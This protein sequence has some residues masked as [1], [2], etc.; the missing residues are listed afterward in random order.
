MCLLLK[1]FLWHFRMNKLDFTSLFQ[2]SAGSEC[3]VLDLVQIRQLIRLGLS[4]F[5]YVVHRGTGR[6]FLI[7]SKSLSLW[8][9]HQVAGYSHVIFWLAV[10][11]NYS[12]VSIVLS[13]TCMDVAGGGLLS[14]FMNWTMINIAKNIENSRLFCCIYFSQDNASAVRLWEI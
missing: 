13:S 5:R 9:H 3:S 4:F 12:D 7:T 10:I 14:S 8:T 11:G 2:L 1:M 6:V